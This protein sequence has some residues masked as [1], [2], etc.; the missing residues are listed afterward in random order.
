MSSLRHA[1]VT[2]ALDE[3]SLQ[4]VRLPDQATCLCNLYR[5]CVHVCTVTLFTAAAKARTWLQ[6]SRRHIPVL[7]LNKRVQ[8]V[9]K[10]AFGLLDACL[11]A[12]NVLSVLCHDHPWCSDLGLGHVPH[13]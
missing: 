2:S 1:L 8:V 9:V 13:I 10:N 3:H 11:G 12:V 6:Y 7:L 5:E 4:D